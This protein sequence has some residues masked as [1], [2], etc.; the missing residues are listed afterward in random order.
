MGGWDNKLNREKVRKSVIIIGQHEASLSIV[1]WPSIPG[2]V[3]QGKRDKK[4]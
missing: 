2:C 1:K 4:P 3:S